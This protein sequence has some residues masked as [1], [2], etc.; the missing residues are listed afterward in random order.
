MAEPIAD[1]LSL[2]ERYGH[3]FGELAQL[4]KAADVIDGTNVYQE[5]NTGSRRIMDNMVEENLLP[6]SRLEGREHFAAFYQAMQEN[7][8]CLILA[9]HYSL[10]DLP[11]MCYLLEHDSGGFGKGIAKELVTIAT[12]KL[13][14]ENPMVRA[15]A[16]GFSR[17]VIYPS[18]S[19][20]KL[21]DPAEEA[22]A[23][24]INMAAMRV[25]D[26]IKRKGFPLLIFPTGT[27]Y[28]PGKPET[29]RGVREM[30]S[31][32]RTFD[33][34]ILVSVNGSLLR[35]S[36]GD[37]ENMLADQVFRDTV[38]M[39]AGPVMNCKAFRQEVLDAYAGRKE[40]VDLKQAV[41]DRIMELLE[42]QHEKYEQL[43]K[44]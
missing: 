6:D 39:T 20:A 28:R 19:I 22:R 37:T 38:V 3:F 14:E 33:V 26:G 13:N 25:L 15:W 12:M 8:R 18:R 7:K 31:Y 11:V 9:E 30:D 10:M 4:S 21:T 44:K 5:A 42:S 29:K 23:R 27:R 35:L 43:R 40:K 24:K 2:K 36:P 34:M 32:L 1:G 16:E 41:S 17:V